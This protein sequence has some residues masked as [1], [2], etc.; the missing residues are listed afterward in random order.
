MQASVIHEAIDW[1]SSL[2]DNV[3]VDRVSF[4]IIPYPVCYFS[5]ETKCKSSQN[6]KREEQNQNSE[7]LI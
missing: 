1:L 4:I 2:K 7:H 6:N 5:D 3:W